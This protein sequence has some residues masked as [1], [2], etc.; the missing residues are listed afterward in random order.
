[1]HF[2]SLDIR[3]YFNIFCFFDSSEKHNFDFRK[4]STE[5]KGN[6][7][8]KNGKTGEKNSTTSKKRIGHCLQKG[9]SKN[10]FGNSLH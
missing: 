8:K 10:L 9:W 3:F 4:D 2:R 5:N 1:M 6:E 7:K